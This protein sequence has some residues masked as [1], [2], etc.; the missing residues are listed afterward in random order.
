MKLDRP[1]LRMYVRRNLNMTK[2][3]QSAQCAHAALGLMKKHPVAE[4][5][6]CVVLEATDA[7]FDRYKMFWC[8]FNHYL[9]RDSG[10]TEVEP[11]SETVLAFWE[12]GGEGDTSNKAADSGKEASPSTPTKRDAVE[13]NTV[14]RKTGDTG[15]LHQA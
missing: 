11:G 5:S 9:V 1:T 10:K 2:G 3:K 13:S 4:Y 14:A 15:E 12:Y 8:R 7:E 6:R